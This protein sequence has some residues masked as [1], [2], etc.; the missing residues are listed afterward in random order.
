MRY[1]GEEVPFGQSCGTCDVC[2]GPKLKIA[3]RFGSLA[4]GKPSLTGV[5]RPAKALPER[6][7][8]SAAEQLKRWR[9]ELSA[10]LG[11]P[12]FIIFNDAGL[13]ALAAALPVSRDEFMRVRGMGES[14]WERF[15]PKIVQICVLARASCDVPQ[16]AAPV[17]VRARRARS[18]W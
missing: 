11:V 1:F 16:V 15:G 6:Y 8:T 3:A 12:P 4:G 10:D 18:T 17:I 14:R 9:R 2:Q 5:A 7:S 13:F